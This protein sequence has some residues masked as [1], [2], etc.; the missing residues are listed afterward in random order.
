V[1]SCSPGGRA[2]KRVLHR[3]VLSLVVVSSLAFTPWSGS[4]AAV[5]SKNYG[6]LPMAFEPTVG[7]ADIVAPG[8]DPNA[9]EL[10][11]RATS[12]STLRATSCSP[13]RWRCPLAATGDLSGKPF[14]DN[15]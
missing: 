12:E 2:L 4:E 6:R 15:D 10:A 7:Q 1:P 8:A 5:L 14:Q 11:G 3:F 9:I 13:P